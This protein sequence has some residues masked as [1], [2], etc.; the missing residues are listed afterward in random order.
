MP[1]STITVILV[2]VPFLM[3]ML[4]VCYRLLKQLRAEP[5]VSTVPPGVRTIVAEIRP[6]DHASDNGVPGAA[7]DRATTVGPPIPQ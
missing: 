7:R 3:V 5:V 4:G 6:L 2:G 1:I